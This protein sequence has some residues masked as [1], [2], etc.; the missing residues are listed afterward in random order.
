[1][2][3]A[4]FMTHIISEICGYARANG[5]EPDETL[6]TVA[7]NIKALLEIS[8]FNQWAGGVTDA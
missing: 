6:E 5:M 4:Q 7:D 1:M 8:T 2:F 3:D